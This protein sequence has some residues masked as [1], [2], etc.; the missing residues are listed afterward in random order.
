MGCTKHSYE[1]PSCPMC[2]AN[3]VAEAQRES[4]EAHRRAMEEHGKSV[5]QTAVR[6]DK[7]AQ[8][9]LAAQM[10][11]DD[12]IAAQ[13]AA[14]AAEHASRLREAMEESNRL[15]EERQEAMLSEMRELQADEAWRQAHQAE[16]Q[17]A[18]H[19]EK[20]MDLRRA[21]MRQESVATLERAIQLDP[22]NVD[23]YFVRALEH[24][25]EDN[26]EGF[27]QDLGRIL[28]LMATRG[29]G[30]A[31]RPDAK[32]DFQMAMMLF[33]LF[34][35]EAAHVVIQKRLLPKWG[36]AEWTHNGTA[37]IKDLFDAEEYEAVVKYT[38]AAMGDKF[39][40]N[41]A[42]LLFGGHHRLGNVEA[43]KRAAAVMLSNYAVSPSVENTSIDSCQPR[44]P[45]DA[46]KWIDACQAADS[47]NRQ[48]IAKVE[49]FYKEMAKEPFP[50]V[51]DAELQRLGDYESLRWSRM[52]YESLVRGR[53][54]Y[55]RSAA[56][57]WTMFSLIFGAP[58]GCIAG[59]VAD[60]YGA[61]DGSLAVSGIL[62]AVLVPLVVLLKNSSWV[63]T[64]K[65]AFSFGGG[66]KHSGPIESIGSLYDQVGANSYTPSPFGKDF[67]LAMVIPAVIGI[68][69][70]VGG[71]M[72]A[73]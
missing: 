51:V 25:S 52:L 63:N 18:A 54:A 10:E 68:G 14:A 35:S 65:R 29:A 26:E 36:V 23:A 58:S 41:L 27:Q 24:R 61:L 46:K 8:Q 2:A 57:N 42:M 73:K 49:D 48:E 13:A 72:V 1:E 6:S 60:K 50:P 19:V 67:I 16:I 4:A 31:G 11:N 34:G 69:L 47:R 55:L 17:S 20:A 12:R 21:G 28:G 43:S 70:L 64:A 62:T 45:D 5:Q 15:A 32:K 71:I 59:C 22:G 7:A 40:G 66:A 38:T 56:V 3:K 37:L 44:N 53:G 39:S 30:I 33:H 9:R